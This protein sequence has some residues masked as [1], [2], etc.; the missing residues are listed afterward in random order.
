MKIKFKSGDGLS[1]V[2]HIWINDKYYWQVFPSYTISHIPCSPISLYDH[3]LKLVKS[4][5]TVPEFNLKLLTLLKECII[6]KCY[7]NKM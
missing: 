6:E 5:T 3:N 4:F 1:G 2:I 7:E